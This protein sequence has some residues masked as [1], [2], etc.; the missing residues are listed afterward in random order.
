MEVKL[1]G[2]FAALVF[3]AQTALVNT[4]ADRHENRLRI[5]YYNITT[6]N[7]MVR[8]SCAKFMLVNF[9]FRYVIP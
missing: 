3:T 7:Q 4:V 2:G 6:G 9:F 1:P 5:T 8:E